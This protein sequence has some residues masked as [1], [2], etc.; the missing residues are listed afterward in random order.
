[1]VVI[2]VVGVVTFGG[3]YAATNLAG[4]RPAPTAAAASPSTL[5][6]HGSLKVTG[7]P[8]IEE[9]RKATA[10]RPGDL[11]AWR[12]LV[13]AIEAL[14]P[15]GEEPA[16]EVVFELVHALSEVLKLD[17]SDYPAMAALAD[18]SFNQQVFDKSIALYERYLAAK[19]DD[20]SVRARYGSALSF[21]GRFSDAERELRSVIAKE[22][23][24]FDAQAYLAIVLAQMGNVEE[25]KRQGAAALDTAP[26]AEARERFAAFLTR[27]TSSGSEP[28]PPA[29]SS[30][31]LE[32]FLRA[33]PIAG[34]KVVSVE[35]QGGGPIRVT[36]QDFPMS[37]M[38]ETIRQ[39]FLNAVKE[40]ASNRPVTFIDRQTG[41]ELDR[42]E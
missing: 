2:A 21:A 39:K 19:P 41:G 32:S 12:A 37:A 27:L 28:Q 22:P 15:E 34:S 3:W 24:R 17:P 40:Q 11:A 18:L 31:N 23:A 6:G 35:E 8:Q 16:K 1:M 30:T 20:L 25:A 13:V 36:M 14:T 9:L 5:P 7:S 33:H 29:T 38:P 26:S 10:E 4:K 42:T